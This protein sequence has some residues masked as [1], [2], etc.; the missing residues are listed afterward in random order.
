MC[1]ERKEEKLRG[2]SARA[3][4]DKAM[5]IEAMDSLLEPLDPARGKL[6]HEAKFGGAERG[7]TA[8]SQFCRLLP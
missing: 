3:S 4:Y 6:R 7:R 8:A 2:L 5:K 1:I